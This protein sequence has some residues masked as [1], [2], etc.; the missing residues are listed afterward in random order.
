MC[1]NRSHILSAISMQYIHEWW[2]WSWWLQYLDKGHSHTST[3]CLTV[4][5]M[6]HFLCVSSMYAQMWWEKRIQENAGMQIQR[7]L[8]ISIWLPFTIQPLTQYNVRYHGVYFRCEYMNR[9]NGRTWATSM[10]LCVIFLLSFFPDFVVDYTGIKMKKKK[11]DGK[12]C[13]RE[14]NLQEMCNTR[15]KNRK[16]SIFKWDKVLVRYRTILHKHMKWG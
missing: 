5:L 8:L 11:R 10:L 12:Y 13:K 3:L 15:W 9:K 4:R 7:K 2:W 16:I 1:A 14:T 6:L